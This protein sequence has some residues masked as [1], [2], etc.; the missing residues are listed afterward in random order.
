[1]TIKFT[2]DT[3]YLSA[4][5]RAHFS[6]TGHRILASRRPLQLCSCPSIFNCQRTRLKRSGAEKPANA[7]KPNSR[8]S[9]R[10]FSVRIGS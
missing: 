1:L 8:T 5:A 6:A 3:E 4:F 7:L 9:H 2:L 10:T